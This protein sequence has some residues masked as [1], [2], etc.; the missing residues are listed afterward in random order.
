M[1]F[2]KQLSFIV[3]ILVSQS[4]FAVQV[5]TLYKVIDQ[6][7]HNYLTLTGNNSHREYV[8]TTLSRVIVTDKGELRETA[9]K[10][11]EVAQWPVIV[12]PGEIVLDTGEEVRVNITKNVN[13]VLDDS[14]LGL[15][16]IPEP[17]QKKSDKKETGLQMAIGYKIWLFIPGTSPLKGEVSAIRKGHQVFIENKTNKVL[18]VAIENCDKVN[19][20]PCSG[21][22]FSLPNTTKSV[23]VKKSKATFS[24]Y[25][26]ANSQEKLK[27]VIL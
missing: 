12:E 22:V 1:Y 19:T 20:E 2:L 16:F 14:V 10:P 21:F 5:S 24:I 17:T 27:E 6:N 15:S 18:R 26:I 7:E 3:M 13:T 8:Y 11:E 4:C 25:T 9:L 23:E